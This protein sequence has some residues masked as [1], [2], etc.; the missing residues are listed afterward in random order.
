MAAV[1]E[2]ALLAAVRNGA[3]A[4]DAEAVM[5]VAYRAA[6]LA[7]GR[8]SEEAALVAH[9]SDAAARVS[10]SAVLVAYKTGVGGLVRSRAWSYALDGHE[11]YILNL[12][13][14]GTFAYD[15]RT[16]QWAQ[17]QTGG[18]GVWNMIQGFQWGLYVVGG[19]AIYP[20][21]W[22]LAPDSPVDE[23][24]R[25]MEH[26]VNGGLP[27]RSRNGVSLDALFLTISSGNI[28]EDGALLQ[29]R[30]SDDQG[31]TWSDYYDVPLELE[32]YSQ[33][34][35]WRSLGNISAPGRIFEIRDIGGMI[36]I[37]DCNATVDG[38]DDG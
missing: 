29:M 20:K 4:R 3:A 1:T 35:T 31:R 14:E 10:D 32:N 7:N 5:L 25:P 2:T 11:F 17:F 28:G 8:V 18:F 16:G 36:R 22:A 33:E 34:I 23:D 6:D 37:D 15:D 21:V 26:K 38:E 30:F 24:W 12:S 19:D 13:E 27:S 9:S